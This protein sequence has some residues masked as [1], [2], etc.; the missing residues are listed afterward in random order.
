MVAVH[1]A[2]MIWNESRCRTEG[3]DV[4]GDD[5]APFRHGGLQHALVIGTAEAWPVR[6]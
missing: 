5:N 1:N 3:T 6:R 4:L 2:E